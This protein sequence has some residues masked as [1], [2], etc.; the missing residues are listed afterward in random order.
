MT[1]TAEELE[2]IAAKER[3]LDRAA[4]EGRLGPRQDPLRRRSNRRAPLD[5]AQSER[6]RLRSR[7][8]GERRG[9]ARS[10]H[11]AIPAR[12]DIIISDVSMPIMTGPEMLQEADPAMIGNAK[13]L[14]LSGYAPE[15]FSHMLEKY[16]VH[17]M[18]KPV[19]MEQLVGRVKELLAA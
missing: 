12:Y 18:S 4:A 14:F 15:S 9:S 6:V 19:T 13:V 16:P 1:P 10:A 5:R 7:R 17:Y 3:A 2:E 8:G 11:G